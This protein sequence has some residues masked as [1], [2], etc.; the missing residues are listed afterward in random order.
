[1]TWSFVGFSGA[2]L[3]LVGLYLAV[4]AIAKSS[5][6]IGLTGIGV[7]VLGAMMGPKRKA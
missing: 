7:I 2:V 3:F 4:V 5:V 6:L 1:M